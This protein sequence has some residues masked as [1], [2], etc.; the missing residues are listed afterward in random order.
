MRPEVVTS[1]A[2]VGDNTPFIALRT[3]ERGVGAISLL[4]GVPAPEGQYDA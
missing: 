3:A 2:R 1:I 4:L